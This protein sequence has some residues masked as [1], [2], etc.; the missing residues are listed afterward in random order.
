MLSNHWKMFLFVDK[1]ILSLSFKKKKKFLFFNGSIQAAEC[2][3][4]FFDEGSWDYVSWIDDFL[5]LT[6][7]MNYKITNLIRKIQ[8]W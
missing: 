7:A 1:E 2:Q 3:I 5:I 4:I 6:F 8:P